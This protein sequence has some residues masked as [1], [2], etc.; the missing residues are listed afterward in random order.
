MPDDEFLNE[1]QQAIDFSFEGLDL[2]RQ[3]VADSSMPLR[4]FTGVPSATS[5]CSGCDAFTKPSHGLG[6]PQGDFN[7]EAVEVTKTDAPENS[8]I[9]HHAV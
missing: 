2:R 7:L 9:R 5:K 1:V 3:R 6:A 4:P 8:E